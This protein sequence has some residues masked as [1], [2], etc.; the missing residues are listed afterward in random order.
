MWSKLALVVLIVVASAMS[1]L[2]YGRRSWSAKTSTLVAALDSARAPSSSA[3]VELREVDQLPAPVRRY[4]RAALTEGQPIIR[5]AYLE[6][7]GTFNMGDTTPLWRAFTS[8]QWVVTNRAGFVWDGRV[9]MAPGIAIHVHDAYIAGTGILRPTVAGLYTLMDLR[10]AGEIACGELMRFFAEAAW[11][12]TVL[13]PSAGAQW[14]AIDEHSARATLKDGPNELTLVFEF[15]ADGM[16]SAIRSEKRA[17]MVGNSMVM[18]PWEVQLSDYRL[19]DG[20]RIPFS[21]EVAWLA[22]EGRLPY[23][24]GS[25][26]KLRYE[27]AE[28]PGSEGRKAWTG[29]PLSSE[30]VVK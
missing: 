9:A 29:E 6:H 4:F 1:A 22:P 11:Y 10:G 26:A 21:G 16:I 13:L 28:A 5:A 25:I 20:M 7:F 23:W 17:R 18:T 24:R 15:S 3:R 2:W 30:Q 12:P 27:F 8:H 14:T 19:Y